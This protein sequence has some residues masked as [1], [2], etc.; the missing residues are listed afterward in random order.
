M[1]YVFTHFRYKCSKEILTITAMLSVNNAVFYRP[2]DK[3]VHAD[4][5]RQNFFLPGGDHITLMN[6]YNQW[7][8]TAHSTQWCFENFIQYRCV[9][10]KLG[11]MHVHRLYILGKSFPLLYIGINMLI[12]GTFST[13]I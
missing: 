2:K 3:V 5:A 12:K 1:S 6:V 10:K 9:G 4:T 13:L 7:E 8:E 11:L